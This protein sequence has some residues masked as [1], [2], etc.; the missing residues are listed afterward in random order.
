MGV[1]I[2]EVEIEGVKIERDCMITNY[3]V[4]IFLLPWDVPL[5]KRVL[6]VGLSGYI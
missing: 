2:E 1:K 5:G 4:K 6:N 3:Y